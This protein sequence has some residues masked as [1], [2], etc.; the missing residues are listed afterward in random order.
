MSDTHDPLVRRARGRRVSR[1]RYLLSVA[2][3]AVPSLGSPMMRRLVRRRTFAVLVAAI[4]AWGVLSAVRTAQETT[5]ALGET[6]PVL[7]L[8]GPIEAGQVVDRTAVRTSTVP[9]SM[10]PDGALDDAGSLDAGPRSRVALAD[11]EVLLADRLTTSAASPI[12][13]SLPPGT[14]ALAVPV[15]PSTTPLGP[16]DVVDVFAAVPAID[17]EVGRV[18]T[19]A[20]VLSTDP[21]RA[22]VAVHSSDVRQTATAVLGGPVTVVVLAASGSRDRDVVDD[23]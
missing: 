12:A 1:P 8:T 3:D 17:F 4:V 6:V 9:R 19:G 2:Y 20:V 23:D 5:A 11:G 18:A 10:V 7:V 16:G 22:V 21:E 14:A 13:A 15:D